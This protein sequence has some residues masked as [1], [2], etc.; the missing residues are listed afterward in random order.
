MTDPFDGR[1]DNKKITKPK[2][3][4]WFKRL[5]NQDK[6]IEEI[7]ITDIRDDLMQAM[8]QGAMEVDTVEMIEGVINVA[9][10]TVRDIMIPRANI[11]TLHGNQTVQEMLEVIIESGHSRFPV[12]G[13]DHEE[14]IGILLSKD[15]LKHFNQADIQVS[16]LLR[17]P[18]YV[19]EEKS[20][21]ALLR[22]FKLNRAHLALVLDEY[23]LLS[24]I[25]TIEDV[26]E[27]IVGEIDDEHDKTLES[28]IRE[29]E[30][31]VY[32]VNAMVPIEAFNQA[33]G[34]HFDDEEAD[35]IGGIIMMYLG[36][37]PKDNEVIVISGLSFV[38]MPFNGKRL[39]MLEVTKLNP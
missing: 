20:V 12:L 32:M 23:G 10:L 1:Q 30:P 26:L 15:L 18:Q 17:K 7:D 25:V 21:N 27:E 31:N 38:V 28:P 22:D 8:A 34:T 2:K 39:E 11:V 3:N 6:N 29:I 36:R 35:A 19:S 33:F 37:L 14:I 5:L 13:A 9:D 24:G 16:S 4:S